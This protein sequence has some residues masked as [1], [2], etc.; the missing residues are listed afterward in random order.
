MY[1]IMRIQKWRS[2]QADVMYNYEN[3]NVRYIGKGEASHSKKGGLNLAEVKSTTAQV[4]RMS[5]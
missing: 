4:N 5:L 1:L 3:V 2:Q